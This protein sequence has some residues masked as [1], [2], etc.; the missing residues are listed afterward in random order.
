MHPRTV[1]L[2]WIFGTWHVTR[3]FLGSKKPYDWLLTI[4]LLIQRRGN[5]GDD[6]LGDEWRDDFKFAA[7]VVACLVF[8]AATV[9]DSWH[10]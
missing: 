4:V 7:P 1:Y 10:T 8:D 3:V 6:F 2:S 9:T 5:C